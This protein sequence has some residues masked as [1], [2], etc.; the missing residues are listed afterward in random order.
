MAEKPSLFVATPCF[1]GVV[2]AIYHESVIA[3]RDA[4][5]R[6]GF[7]VTS[8]LR[9]GD[10]MITRARN[11]MLAQFMSSRAT[12]ILFIDADIGFDPDQVLRLLAFDADFVAA[13]YPLKKV[14][15]ERMRAHP[16]FPPEKIHHYVYQVADLKRID[17]RGDFIK[18]VYVG[19]GFLMLSRQ[20][21]ERLC[22]AH[23]EL[24]YERVHAPDLGIDS[25]HR[26]A[27]FDPMID[28]TKTSLSEDYAFCR[29]WTNTGG[30]I[31]VDSASRL[32]HVGPVTFDGD[33]SATLNRMPA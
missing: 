21:V 4:A 3:L 18:A 22:A 27:L 24:H 17:G 10:S 23:P 31:W 9:P 15:W 2:T 32:R 6:L 29:R 12:H 7:D 8:V 26:Y 1:G 5:P 30:E 20:A 13:A 33:L 14:N 19:S 11:E 28:D 16:D 25:R